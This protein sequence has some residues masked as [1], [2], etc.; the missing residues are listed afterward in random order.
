ME[1][2][3]RPRGR[4]REVVDPNLIPPPKWRP[5][6]PRKPRGHLDPAPLM[7]TP[8]E[9]ST[10]DRLEGEEWERRIPLNQREREWKR[11]EKGIVHGEHD[12]R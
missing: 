3:K 4:P 1:P 6:Q 2:P 5:G 9:R 10:P 8:R 7:N 11:W 12:S